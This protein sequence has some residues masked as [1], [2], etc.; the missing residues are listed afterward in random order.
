MF[1]RVNKVV[2]LLVFVNKTGKNILTKFKPIAFYR[3]VLAA[4]CHWLRLCGLACAALNR[5]RYLCTLAVL[6]KNVFRRI[7]LFKIS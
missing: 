7:M 1:G 6:P 2:I 4:C 5:V 3:Q